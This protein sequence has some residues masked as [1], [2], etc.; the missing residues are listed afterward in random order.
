M[1]G[2]TTLPYAEPLRI[3]CNVSGKRS[4][5]HS[6][7]IG[8]KL[9]TTEAESGNPRQCSL[10]GCICILPEAERGHQAESHEM[11]ELQRPQGNRKGEGTQQ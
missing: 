4:E 3:L 5:K 11:T 8:S 6:R 2:P 9:S 7:K 10:M 1:G